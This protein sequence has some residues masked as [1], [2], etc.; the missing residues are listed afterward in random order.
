MAVGVKAVEVQVNHDVRDPSSGLRV[1]L[2][3]AYQSIS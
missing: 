3:M 1:M 2:D